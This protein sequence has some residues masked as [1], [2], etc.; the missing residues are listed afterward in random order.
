VKES[1]ALDVTELTAPGDL[2]P[3]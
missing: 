1:P 3:A 2:P